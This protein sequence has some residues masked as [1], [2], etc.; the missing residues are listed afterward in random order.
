VTEEYLNERSHYR[1][2]GIKTKRYMRGKFVPRDILNDPPLDKDGNYRSVFL[3]V[4][5]IRI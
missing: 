1:E 5:R 4:L 2:T 3:A